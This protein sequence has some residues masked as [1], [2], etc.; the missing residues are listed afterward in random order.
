[1][2]SQYDRRVRARQLAYYSG[3]PSLTS[4]SRSTRM[5]TRI[6]EVVPPPALPLSA[7]TDER[8]SRDIILWESLSNTVLSNTV[9]ADEFHTAYST[10]TSVSYA[11]AREY[12]LQMN[13][14][15]WDAALR[16]GRGHPA[17]I[18]NPDYLELLGE[19]VWHGVLS[20]TPPPF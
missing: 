16:V 7:Q 5:R 14:M 4:R 1:M 17:E 11:A 3:V 18:F 12:G 20:P 2:S 8:T 10:N 9:S 13:R 15:F 6:A 19:G